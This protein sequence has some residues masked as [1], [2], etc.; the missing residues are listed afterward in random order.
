VLLSE[1]A[2]T[3]AQLDEVDRRLAVMGA[4]AVLRFETATLVTRTASGPTANVDPP[5]LSR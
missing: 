2:L 5:F 4:I 1:D 3:S